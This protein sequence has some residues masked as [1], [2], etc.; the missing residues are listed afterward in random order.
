IK[1]QAS[2]AHYVAMTKCFTIFWGLVALGFALFA[3]MAENLIQASNI[4]ASLFYGVVLGLFL[5]AFFVKYIKGTAIFWGGITAQAMVLVYALLVY[6]E[7]LPPSLSI[8][9]LWYNVI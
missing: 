4:V 1:R 8:S 5:V 9:Y 3:H 2:D 6:L 7:K